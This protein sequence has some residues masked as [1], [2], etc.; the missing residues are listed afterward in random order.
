MS[1][2]AR[3]WVDP[4]DVVQQALLEV[5]APLD[6]ETAADL[7]D[8][9]LLRRL[10]RAAWTRLVDDVRRHQG[11]AGESMH[12][13]GAAGVAAGHSSDGPVTR[14]DDR[15]WLRGLVDQLPAGQREVVLLVAF[16]GCTH[17]EAGERLGLTEDAVR[18]RYAKA[19]VELERR[20]E[21]ESPTA[22]R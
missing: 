1:T 20:L 9:E 15:R 3:R 8:E 7:G 6:P 4:E 13:V 16:E 14:D 2:A 12:P 11:E 21:G 19:R 18:K 5:L 22:G 10:Q 17:R